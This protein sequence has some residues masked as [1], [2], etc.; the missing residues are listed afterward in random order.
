M[1][2]GL[3]HIALLWLSSLAVCTTDTLREKAER[4]MSETPL[5]D[6]H[7]DLPWQIRSLYNNQLNQVDL[8]TLN[9]THTNIPKIKAGHLGAQFWAAYVPCDCQYKDAVRQTLEQIDLVHRMTQ[10]YPEHLKFCTSS[11]EILQAFQENKTASL[12]GVEGGHSIDSSMATLR[13]FYQ[14][15]VRYLTLTHSC[16][17]PWADNWK[18]DN[19]DE[20]PESN[21]LS[22]F[23]KNLIK[24]MN[25]IGMIIDLAHVSQKVMKDVLDISEAPVIF[26]HSSAYKICPSKRN[27]PD[28]ILIK[29]A[30]K[31]GI[32]MVNFYNNYV[33]CNKTASLSDVAD[34]FDHIRQVGGAAIVG[35]GGDYDGV[36]RVPQGLEDVSKYPDLVAELLNRGWTDKEVKEALGENLLR[37]F[38]K[39]EEV[40]DQMSKTLP[41]D[42]P[43]PYEEVNN[44]CRTSYGYQINNGAEVFKLAFY[45]LLIFSIA[46]QY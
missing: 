25:R 13:M 1:C 2:S 41:N 40:R 32:V 37:V 7:N 15:G 6:G 10:S 38:K 28:D 19:G 16:N 46:L 27:V 20:N 18:V 42:I 43:I 23:G 4:L 45:P 36:S 26:S 8:N 12:I 24:E 3:Q 9:K 14:L 21:G 29:V 17:A 5:I 22:E 39:V 44:P 34:H 30:E 33:T 35:F 11:Q 31:K